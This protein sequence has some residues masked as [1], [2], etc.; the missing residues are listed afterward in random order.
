M[1]A[2]IAE[3]RAIMMAAVKHFKI[4]MPRPESEPL[5]SQTTID[6]G[7]IKPTDERYDE[8]ITV[9]RHFALLPTEDTL[10]SISS[11][12]KWPLDK[13]SWERVKL[14]SQSQSWQD[15]PEGLQPI[16][17][18]WLH[19]RISADV[20]EFGY[21]TDGYPCQLGTDWDRY[22]PHLGLVEFFKEHTV[23]SPRRQY[24]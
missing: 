6:F 17:E 2:D 18:W 7:S 13:P 11:W 15:L 20:G 9:S 19:D 12:D 16:M 23:I 5:T 4:E 8:E 14:V 10:L 24:P 1:A 22:R 21:T 3:L